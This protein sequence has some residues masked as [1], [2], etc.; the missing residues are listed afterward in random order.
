VAGLFQAVKYSTPVIGA[1]EH[2]LSLRCRSVEAY[3]FVA[4][5]GR[6][7]SESLSAILEAA[8]N[9]VTFHEPY[10]I[11]YSDYPEN[12][13]KKAYFDEIFY[14]IKRINMKRAA[15]GHRY[16]AETNHQFIKN[17]FTQSVDY[18]GDKLRVIHM[19]RDPVR[20]A[21]SFY[22]IDSVP[23]DTPQGKLYMLDP[24]DDDNLIQ[25]NDILAGDP[26]FNH[27]FFRCLWYWYE[28][29]TRV[30]K[31]KSEFPNVIW[32]ELGTEELN[33]KDAL[34]SM[35]NQLGVKFNADILERVV[36]SRKNPRKSRDVKKE[37]PADTAE[38]ADR[39]LKKMEDRYGK[40]FWR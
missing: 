19:V 39:L 38:M 20:V 24:A 7:G 10:P 16:Y 4:T 3:I 12:A 15:A 18:F 9:A 32:S 28:I 34:I 1:Y 37:V 30:K 6:S 2:L 14:K 22:S 17:Y 35:L 8:D 5:T 29:E 21:S 13:D 36:G 11:M 40:Q 26:D 31:Y 23:G 33:D 25:I 27:G